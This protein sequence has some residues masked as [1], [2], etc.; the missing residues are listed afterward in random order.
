MAT[1]FIKSIQRLSIWAKVLFILVILLL[2]LYA[3]SLLAKQNVKEG[4]SEGFIQGFSE[5]NNFV[6]KQDNEV[7]DKFYVNIYDDLLHSEI[8][9]N[10][11]I[12]EI[13]NKT[14]PDSRS[15]ILDI[16]SGTGHHAGALKKAGYEVQGVDISPAMVAKASQNYPDVPFH[17]GNILKTMM[18]PS[19][20]FTHIT[21]LYFTIY[22]IKD[23]AQL[24]KNCF[25]WLMPGGHLVIHVVDR[26]KF[27][28]I[29]PASSVMLGVS[30]QKYAKERITRSNV[31]FKDFDYKAEFEEIF[32]NDLAIFR[33]VFKDKHSKRVR[34]HEHNLYMPKHESIVSLAK[35]VGFIMVGKINMKDV[36]YEHQYL[37]VLQKPE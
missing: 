12:G 10:Y 27:D 31:A 35:E 19:E 16:G 15:I 11:E 34:Q 28:P 24:L 17:S 6:L 37:V 3:G 18:F 4:F 7:F 26:E 1:S 8:K 14:V 21:C 29:I 23:K 13:V 2:V 22:Q 36:N 25:H 33:E 5:Q 20:S 9:N 30:P 32:P